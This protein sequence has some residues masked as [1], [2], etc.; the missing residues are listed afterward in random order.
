MHAHVKERP[1]PVA[2][3][4]ICV[5]CAVF[6][7]QNCL[8]SLCLVR[9]YQTVGC[10]FQYTLLFILLLLLQFIHDFIIENRL[11]RYYRGICKLWR[12]SVI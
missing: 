8:C 10:I 12:G 3:V 6:N 9:R 5:I 1:K 2:V 7:A 4:C 11:C